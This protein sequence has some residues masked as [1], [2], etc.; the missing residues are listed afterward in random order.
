M[1][2]CKFAGNLTQSA[3]G[4]SK[5]GLKGS[6]YAVSLCEIDEITIANKTA[7]AITMKT[8]PLTTNPFYWYEIQ[9]KKGTAGF[10]NELA[11]GNNTFANQSIT[12]AV[13]G[14]TAASLQTL[15]ELAT[16]EVVF[17][18]TDTRGINHLLGRLDGLKASAGTVG[19]GIAADDLY[20]ATMTFTGGETELSN[21][22]ASGTT[23]DVWDGAAVVSVTLP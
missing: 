22:V 23:I 18:C 1:S 11:I 19:A 2:C 15:E 13:E 12:F 20:G 9:Y 8:D 4:M 10:N 5:G 21:L 3:C 14:L 7:S 6:I 17:I 16:A